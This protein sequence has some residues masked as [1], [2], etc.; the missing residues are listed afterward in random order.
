MKDLINSR[1]K[2]VVSAAINLIAAFKKGGLDSFAYYLEA[3]IDSVESLKRIDHTKDSVDSFNP[4]LV[5]DIG[6]ASFLSEFSREY[7]SRSRKSYYDCSCE[8]CTCDCYECID[9]GQ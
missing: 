7:E 9:C 1:Q 8:C 6:R 4:K 2:D 3:L 5:I